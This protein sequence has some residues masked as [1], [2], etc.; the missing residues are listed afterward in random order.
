M[1][2]SEA[3]ALLEKYFEGE[4]S[5]E[6]E[7]RLR[8]F[9]RQTEM[10]PAHLQ[11]YAAQFA[12]PAGVKEQQAGKLAWEEWLATYDRPAKKQNAV[13]RWLGIPAGWQ[14]AASILFLLLGFS[15]GIF[16]NNRSGAG[17]AVAENS[18]ERTPE[19]VLQVT[20]VLQYNQSKSSTASERIQAIQQ[21][22]GFET[23]D[24]QL[25]QVLINTMNLDENVNVRLAACETLYRFADAPRVREAFI[26][27]LRVQTDPA[28]QIALIDALTE[29]QE[30][31]A[32][33]EMQRLVQDEQALEIV[34]LRA[35]QGVGQ[36]I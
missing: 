15:G 13:R 35:Q 17:P 31:R 6:E 28:V 25:I 10:V 7:R 8:D 5:L 27:S 1:N 23:A 36:L 2:A 3:E 30:K 4:T 11:V 26:R 32:M 29:L 9:F 19:P 18:P 24:S 14:I 12:Y 21:S 34:R 16:Y 33:A 20:R 22:A